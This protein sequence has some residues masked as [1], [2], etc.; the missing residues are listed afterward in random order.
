MFEL[1]EGTITDSNYDQVFQRLNETNPE[2]IQKLDLQTCN[3]NTFLS[4]VRL[5]VHQDNRFLLCGTFTNVY[6]QMIAVMIYN[7]AL[8]LGP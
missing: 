7:T 5:L 8:C 4:E 6:F 3:L 1:P 2:V